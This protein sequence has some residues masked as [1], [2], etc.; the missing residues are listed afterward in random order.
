MNLII[1]SPYDFLWMKDLAG[2]H[3]CVNCGNS[4]FDK[5]GNRQYCSK[6][7][8]NSARSQRRAAQTGRD[9]P[10]DLPAMALIFDGEIFCDPS[11]DDD[12]WLRYC[13][14]PSCGKTFSADRFNQRYCSR[15]CANNASRAEQRREHVVTFIGIDGEGVNIYE[16]NYFTGKDE[17]IKHD[18]VLLVACGTGMQPLILHKNGESLSTEEI[19]DWLYNVVFATHP[20]ACFVSFAMGYDLAQWVRNLPESRA[21]K[22]FTKDGM[23]SRKRT[24]VPNPTPF[25]VYWRP[26][27]RSPREWEIDTLGTKR[28]K[29]RL[30]YTPW[31]DFNAPRAERE[32]KGPPWMH[33]CDV[34]S[35]FQC[36]FL[37]A[38]DPAPRLAAGTPSLVTPEEYET[39]KAGKARRAD[40]AFDETMI[41][42]TVLECDAL[43]RLMT[44]LN[45]G[46]VDNNVKLRRDKYFG[47][48]QTAQAM[49]DGIIKNGAVDFSRKNVEEKVPFAFRD[50]ARQAYFGG[51]FEIMK[52][53][54]HEGIAYEYDINSAYPKVMMELRCLLHG[55][56][57]AG[58]GNP[59]RSARLRP[60]R[61]HGFGTGPGQCL[62]LVDARV[63]G[64]HPRIGAMLHRRRD[65]R[66]LRPHETA[67]WYWLHELEIAKR[68]GLIDEISWY[69]WRAYVPCDCSKPL[70]PLKDLYLKR[71][72]VGKNT[73]SGTALKLMYN[74]GYGKMAQS[75]GQ[76]K[77]ANAV[78][79]SLITAGCRCMIL[80]AIATHP[81]GADGVLMV[82]TD[83]IYFTAPHRKL[84]LS[85]ALGDWELTEHRDL[86]LFKPG[87]YWNDNTRDKARNGDW[88]SIKFKSRGVNMVA[89]GKGILALDDAFAA[90][91]PGNPWPSLPIEI[92]F[93]VI[94]PQQALARGKWYLCGAVSNAH[95]IEISADP[96]IKRF[97]VGPGWSQPYERQD[98]LR[99]TPYN[100]AFGDETAASILLGSAW[101]SLHPDGMLTGQLSEIFFGDKPDI[102]AI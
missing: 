31:R 20:G 87:T 91:R 79:A 47:P 24:K 73:P 30:R 39:I 76:P 27:R 58:E 92:P 88:G 49:M 32:A 61:K 7:S 21:R 75:I 19:L 15:D 78:Y 23:D 16:Y 6:C 45:Q 63:T 29:L 4:F 8:H 11:E 96:T 83:G 42:Y 12:P 95:K 26:D 69:E 28:I 65:G 38:I 97:A 60:H 35:F 18:Y 10:A 57:L 84:P 62:C 17:I 55:Q 98:P 74:S 56:Y 67:G 40:A 25:P 86:M 22:L 81:D 102:G 99:S 44:E 41:K 13:A 2:H 70:R 59:Y 14:A 80:D 34:F 1:P 72:E 101:E 43:A 90:M 50:A 54:P 85:P 51:W 64:S 68:A 5:R 100:R 9:T 46:M 77:Y 53:G 3:T 37:K 66:V 48:G 94:S 71:L 89:L 52:H 93:Q 33:I 36:S 82:A